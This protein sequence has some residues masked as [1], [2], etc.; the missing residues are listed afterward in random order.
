MSERRIANV[1]KSKGR[2]VRIMGAFGCF[3]YMEFKGEP[4]RIRGS[5]L[6]LFIN[7]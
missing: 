1:Q 6:I 2:T 4:C 5:R 7:M 3:H